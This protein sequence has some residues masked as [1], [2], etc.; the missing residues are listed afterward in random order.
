MKKKIIPYAMI[1][2]L[3]LVSCIKND[4][5]ISQFERTEYLN[6]VDRYIENDSIALIEGIQC[7]SSILAILDYHSGY[8]FSLFSSTGEYIRRFGKIGQGPDEILLGCYGYLLN[9]YFWISYNDP[10]FIA[11]YNIDSLT[12][13]K[14][15]E[16]YKTITKYNIRDGMFLRSIPLSDSLFLGTGVYKADYQYCLFNNKNKVLDYKLKIF[17]SGDSTFNL[18][19]KLL[20]NQGVFRKCPTDNK[21]VNFIYYS[22]NIDFLEVR[23]LKIS[24]IKSIRLKNPEFRIL[25]SG[26]INQTFPNDNNIIGYIDVACTEN[27]VYALYSDKLLVDN[28]TAN[29]LCSNTLLVYD[30]K[31]NPLKT[32]KLNV[33]AYYICVNSEKNELYIATKN[34]EQS[35]CIAVYNL[36]AATT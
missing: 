36:D 8:S 6:K 29:Y 33:D 5:P 1:L 28:G 26:P 11:K 30:W 35:W 24:V 21:F 19:H 34:Q 17:N 2:C 4:S 25:R 9:S 20:S 3:S 22:S 31:G 32:L 7:D 23:D 18:Y 27:N 14:E 10:G 15:K 16:N 12:K 13:T